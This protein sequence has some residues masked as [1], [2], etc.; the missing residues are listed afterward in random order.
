MVGIMG[1]TG[2]Q[3]T[4]LNIMVIPLILGIGIDYGVHLVHRYH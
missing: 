3:L 4:L 2:M 1:L